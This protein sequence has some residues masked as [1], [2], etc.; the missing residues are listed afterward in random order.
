MSATFTTAELDDVLPA[1]RRFA[2]SLTRNEVRAND[3]VQD[4]V[5][6]ALVKAEYFQPGTNLRSWMFTL[7]RRVFLNQVR[8]RKSRGV[9]IDL[10][11][12]PQAALSEKAGQLSAVTYREVAEHFERFPN[13]DKAVLSLVVIE[14]MKY[15]E[16][17]AVLDVPV[18]T[19]RSRLSRAR[20]RLKELMGE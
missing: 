18:G 10:E 3:L 17:A 7:C 9:A 11:D 1:L 13:R 16:A 4:S 19:V 5:E 6:R 20:A 12:A 8:K 2:I 15:E 14:G